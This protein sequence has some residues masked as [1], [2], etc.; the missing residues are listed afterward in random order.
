MSGTFL[1][2]PQLVSSAS[3]GVGASLPGR[4]ASRPPALSARCRTAGPARHSGAG[5][6]V[7]LW[8]LT[9][10]SRH[11]TLGEITQ[12]GVRATEESRFFISRGRVAE[13]GVAPAAGDTSMLAL[14]KVPRS[15]T[16][17]L[18]IREATVATTSSPL[19][20]HSLTAR[21]TSRSVDRIG[22]AMIMSSVLAP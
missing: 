19:F 4:G 15:R 13:G 18:L 2:H 6:R 20:V 14:A 22:V 3:P 1:N 8:F 17:P 16:V 11:V 5:P 10:Y 12:E 9:P 7:P 21:T